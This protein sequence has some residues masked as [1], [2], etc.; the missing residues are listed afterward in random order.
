MRTAGEPG[1]FAAVIRHVGRVS[2]TAYE[3]PVVPFPHGDRFVIVL[4]YGARPDWVRNVL[5]AGSAEL[6][7]EGHT[8]TVGSPL[9]RQVGSGDVPASDMRA[10]RLFG[11]TECME[12]TRL[13]G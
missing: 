8:F 2:G 5:T 13:A 12:L 11:N 10:M 4:P 9:V 1:A 6:T 3:T 7:H